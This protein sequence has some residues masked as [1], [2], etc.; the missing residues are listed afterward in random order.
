MTHKVTKLPRA[1]LRIL[2]LQVLCHCLA[3]ATDCLG[4]EVNPEVDE[5]IV[6]C[7]GS[8]YVCITR[9]E[10]EFAAPRGPIEL[11]FVRNAQFGAPR[12]NWKAEI[13]LVDRIDDEVFVQTDL[14]EP[15][16]DDSVLF[17]KRLS[18][19]P[20]HVLI[21]QESERLILVDDFCVN[22]PSPIVL[23]FDEN[24]AEVSHLE[25]ADVFGRAKSIKLIK[26]ANEDWTDRVPMTFGALD[27]SGDLLLLGVDFT[28]PRLIDLNSGEAKK[29]NADDLARFFSGQNGC[30]AVKAFLECNFTGELSSLRRTHA[31]NNVSLMLR[32]Y[33]AIAL[34]AQGDRTGVAF[35]NELL[36]EEA[37][38]EYAEGFSDKFAEAR[39]IVFFDYLDRL[40]DKWVAD[41]LIHEI[42]S[43]SHFA[44][45]LF[46]KRF[47]GSN[48]MA[49]RLAHSKNER[50]R[51][52]L[53]TLLEA[54]HLSEQESKAILDQLSVD[55]SIHVRSAARD[56]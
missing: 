4:D 50:V 1:H 18:R 14:A 41:A 2:C 10:T 24:G 20:K 26:Q 27:D 19:K 7:D 44:G 5:L 16:P 45:R 28:E 52:E 23:V 55:P 48:E 17:S 8:Y 30:V 43:G 22:S 3:L 13:Q 40:D 29:A 34:F 36:N 15:R 6:S 56:R 47:T 38:E 49:L 37:R 46:A 12:K 31:K 54:F 53:L 21:D 11:T 33:C 42:E 39:S 35:L 51:L 25:L 32:T 9:G